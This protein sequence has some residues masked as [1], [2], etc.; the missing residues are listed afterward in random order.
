MAGLAWP[1]LAFHDLADEEA[2]SAVLAVLKS[3][4][5]LRIGIQYLCDHR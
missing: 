3:A 2:H 4:I 5:G 1:L